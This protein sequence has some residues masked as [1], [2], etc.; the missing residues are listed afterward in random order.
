[1]L[2]SSPA[3][4]RKKHQPVNNID[5]TRSEKYASLIV[6]SSTG[7]VLHKHNAHE[8]RHPASLTK[9]M[10][11]YLTLQAIKNKQL[12]FNTMLPV[13][14]WAAVPS[15]S[16]TK[17]WLKAGQKISVRDALDA[18]IVQSANDA[19]VVIAEAISGSEEAFADKMTQTAYQLGMTDTVFRNSHGLHDSDQVTTAADM[20]KLGIALRRDFPQYYHMFSKK[21]FVYKGVVINGHNRVLSKYRWAD[22]LKTGYVAASGFNLVTSASRPE[23]RIVAVVLGGPTAAT[24]D[25]HMISLLDKGFAKLAASKSFS[26]S[27]KVASNNKRGAFEVAEAE[28][29]TDIIKI[30]NSAFD[31]A[32]A[33]ALLGPQEGKTQ[34]VKKK[35]NI[36]AAK[37][38]NVKKVQPVATAK[39]AVQA[40]QKKNPKTLVNVS[41][42]KKANTAIKSQR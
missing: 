6:N 41:K 19:S 27:N 17:L 21:S 35:L 42:R 13:S 39:H 14:S 18:I 8:L 40:S 12:S 23:G 36:A 32:D 9:L 2:S 33:S 3:E 28:L 10:T 20:A 7:E 38:K 15:R 1:M 31:V 16:P 37:P 11:T 30:K 5:I 25:T 29:N 22:G 24:R 34:I 26:Q 4:A